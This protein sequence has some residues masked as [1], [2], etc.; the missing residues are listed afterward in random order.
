[1]K[2]VQTQKNLEIV[3]DRLAI[4]EGMSLPDWA[5]EQV[6][7]IVVPF[8]GNPT[9]KGR[10]TVHTAAFLVLD[11]E[12]DESQ[13][14]GKTK[15]EENIVLF[16]ILE[17]S[18]TITPVE[19]QVDIQSHNESPQGISW[20]EPVNE[21]S[22]KSKT[23]FEKTGRKWGDRRILHLDQEGLSLAEMDIGDGGALDS[24][25]RHQSANTSEDISNGSIEDQSIDRLVEGPRQQEGTDD[26]ANA[27]QRQCGR[28][29]LND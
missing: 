8:A 6:H 26:E 29:S 2:I 7:A 1:M 19:G 14:E 13:E 20:H 15:A 5:I 23:E 27:N 4:E 18:S 28:A 3:R 11:P 21:V 25:A 22:I 12:Q 16:K 17:L 10:V 24:R 9:P